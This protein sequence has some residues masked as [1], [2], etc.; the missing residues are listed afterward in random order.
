MQ[1]AR[2]VDGDDPPY[3]QKAIDVRAKRCTETGLETFNMP[4][5]GLAG[6][7]NELILCTLTHCGE[8]ELMLVYRLLVK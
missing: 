1:S 5:R 3:K 6:T 4:W 2:L 7:N 8:I